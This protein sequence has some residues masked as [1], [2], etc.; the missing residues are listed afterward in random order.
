MDYLDKRHLLAPGTRRDLLSNTLVLVVPADRKEQ[1]A[2]GPGFDLRRAARP[3]RAA[4]DGR[5]GP[6]SG[7]QLRQAGADRAR[8]VGR[9]E[10][11]HRAAADVRGALFLVERGEAPAG[12]VYATDA[13]AVQGVAVAGVF[14]ADSHPPVTYPFAI[15]AGHDSADARELLAFRAG[16]GARD[17][18]PARLH[19]RGVMPDWLSPAEWEAVRLTLGVA[20]SSVAFG[21]PVAIGL[22]CCSRGAASP[23]RPA[24][25]RSRICRWCCRPWSSAGSCCCCSERAARWAASLLAWFGIRLVFTTGAAT[26]ACAVMAFPLMVRPIR[27]AIEGIDAVWTRPRARSGPERWTGC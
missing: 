15:V 20:A 7:R 13:A 8:P 5:P 22:R 18:R 27:L 25:L 16:G 19:A 3:E 1:V 23:A 9:R 12:I 10:G 4:C 26:L 14:P 17:L 11:S 6:C 2:I 21:L 24:R